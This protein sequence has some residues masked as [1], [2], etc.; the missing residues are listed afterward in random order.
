MEVA[1]GKYLLRVSGIY[2]NNAGVMGNKDTL[3]FKISLP[4]AAE[5]IKKTICMNSVSGYSYP[6]SF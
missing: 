1:K 5:A 6:F 4:G 3:R 2:T